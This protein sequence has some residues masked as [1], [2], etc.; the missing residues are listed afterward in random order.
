MRGAT[1]PRLLL[2][3]ICARVLLPGADHGTDGLMARI[4]RLEKRA[5]ITGG[6][7]SPTVSSPAPPPP[8]EHP[9]ESVP[10]ASAPPVPPPDPVPAPTEAPAETPAEAPTP[11]AVTQQAPSREQREEEAPAAAPEGGLTLVDVRRLWPDIVEATKLRRRVAWMHLTQ[12]S[13]V[14]GVEGNTLV[15]GF[16]NAGAR[17]S[18]VNGGC[19][20]ILRQAAIDV[21]GVDWKVDAIVD[22]GARP[23][24]TTTP[25]KAGAGTKSPPAD[26]QPDPTADAP[27]ADARAD[28][29]PADH[30]PGA[31]ARGAISRTR[32]GEPAEDP[33]ARA[34]ADA[35]PDDPDADSGGLDT[36]EL[37]QRELGAQVIEETPNK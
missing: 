34:D 33:R 20:E 30:G 16:N 26:P 6:S 32:P 25:S 11:E 24:S 31:A 3:L 27:P 35:H 22:P 4:D 28:P 23:A 10:E 9:V 2:E 18:F 37:L 13:Q 7:P 21:V 12:N 36:T 15:L 1:A 17:D 29:A 19:D 14:I 5:A 8:A